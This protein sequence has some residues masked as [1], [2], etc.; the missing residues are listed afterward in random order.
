MAMP[1]DMSSIPNLPGYTYQKRNKN[2]GKGK[3][4]DV[5]SGVRIEHQ[6]GVTYEKPK[7]VKVMKDVES[8]RTGSLPDSTTRNE[9]ALPPEVAARGH[10]ELPAWDALDRHVLR[11]YGYFKEAVIETNLENWRTRKCI[12]MFYLEDDTC[13][14][15]EKKQDNSGIPQGTLIRRHRFPG[16]NGGFLS[17]DDLQVG[18]HLN[19]YGRT[20]RIVDADAYTREYY[21]RNG[22]E[23]EGPEPVEGDAF[24]DTTS[25]EV[26]YPGIPRTHERLYREIELGGGHINADMQQFLEWDRKVC[27]FFAVQ[28]DLSMPTFERRPFVILY[29]L[30]DDTVEIREQYPLN[31]GRDTFPIFF[32]RGRLKKGNVTVLGPMDQCL[33]QSEYTTA[34]DLAVGQ[35]INLQGNDFF[36]YDADEFT[37]GYFTEELKMPLGE[38]CDVQLPERAVPRPATPP[39]TGF[40]SWDDS[41]TSVLSLIPKP[42]KKDLIKLFKYQD[43]IIRFTARFAN[44]KAEDQ[45][46]LFVVNF[47]LFDDTLS[48]H[49]P[50]QRNLGIV[51]GRF[52]EKGVH[53]NQQTGNLFTHEDLYCGAL[54]EVRNRKF[55]LL[56]CDEYTRNFFKNGGGRN[57]RLDLGAVMEKMREGMRQHFPLVRDVF[58][59][60]DADKDGVLTQH[61][62]KQALEKYGFANLSD[63]E[64]LIIMKYFDTRQD[65]Q[66]S[67]NEFCDALLD[68]DYTSTMMKMRPGLKQEA[69]VG[70]AEKAMMK[71]QERG[72]TD[73]VRKAVRAMSDVIYKQGQTSHKLMKEFQHMTHECTVSCVQIKKA[74]SNIGKT[75]NL[76]EVQRT[77]LFVMPD[78]DLNKINYVE[79]LKAMVA[80]YHD[81]CRVR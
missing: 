48:I 60:F 55:L 67:Y 11:F 79:F 56:D 10:G 8:W 77:V 40:G 50:P 7:M 21:R 9:F 61:E 62:F 81:M 26:G 71:T 24:A 30:A 19:L 28:D 20:I 18:G 1:M 72:E 2:H 74:M 69:D 70:Y 66:V 29:F 35:M 4:F 27:R 12:I 15:C 25:N 76:E 31:C 3:S 57:N 59:K 32:R 54:I 39:Y 73:A 63:E 78:A 13:H 42:P 36:I 34:T 23:L 38:R 68:E 17:P 52:L 47:H 5:V 45:E 37:R 51:T 22:C 49:E 80:I 44:P 65:G 41:M 58:R 6:E 14:V 64:V 33:P 43:K 53:L 75:F 16:P 46:R